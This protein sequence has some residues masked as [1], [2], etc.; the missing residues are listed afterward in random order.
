MFDHYEKEYI[1]WIFKF[2]EKYTFFFFNHNI[3]VR[4]T[5]LTR[6]EK[7]YGGVAVSPPRVPLH[8]RSN[9]L[10]AHTFPL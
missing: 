1:Y 7:N 8:W 9:A 5:I 10:L 2:K 4:S 6:V 3:N